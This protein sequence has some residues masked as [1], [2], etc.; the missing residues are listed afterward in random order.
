MFKEILGYLGLESRMEYPGKSL[1]RKT[2]LVGSG[3]LFLILTALARFHVGSG[4]YAIVEA[5]NTLANRSYIIDAFLYWFTSDG[6]TV[7]VVVAVLFGLWFAYPSRTDRSIILY[8]LVFSML[9]GTLSR[10]AQLAVRGHVRL[11]HDADVHVVLPLPVD[12]TSLTGW[13][14][15][16]SD[17]AAL[18]AGL[19]LSVWLISRRIGLVLIGFAVLVNLCRIYF[20]IHYPTDVLAGSALGVFVVELGLPLI[21]SYPVQATLDFEQR[22]PGVFYGLFF[23]GSFSVASMLLS[24][25]DEA[26]TIKHAIKATLHIPRHHYGEMGGKN[27]GCEGVVSGER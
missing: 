22:R 2:I 26:Q 4:D 13:G 10:L 27:G 20:C 11:L 15:F 19:V 3:V 8:G 6:V 1:S 7:A 18:L 21:R 9:V 24:V 23:Y 12:P 14:S 17:H 25:R 16:P 5:L